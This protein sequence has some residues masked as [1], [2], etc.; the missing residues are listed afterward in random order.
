MCAPRQIW[1]TPRARAVAGCLVGAG[2]Q[3]SIHVCCEPAVA[4]TG[5]HGRGAGTASS[6]GGARGQSVR[7]KGA[8]HSLVATWARAPGPAQLLAGEEVWFWARVQ[9]RIWK[10]PGD[11][12]VGL[13]PSPCSRHSQAEVPD[14]DRRWPTG[15]GEGGG[16]SSPL[17][18]A[19]PC[20]PHDPPPLERLPSLLLS[21]GTKGRFLCEQ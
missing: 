2:R 15:A 4:Q 3:S 20:V 14:R 12:G 7:L 11:R 8:R 17:G 5:R 16:F 13:C 21:C 10:G 9:G 18:G 1:G 6:T 19:R